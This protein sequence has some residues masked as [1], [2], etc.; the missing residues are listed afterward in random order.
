MIIQ[1]PVSFLGREDT[2]LKGRLM[3]E[4]SGILAWAIEG[5]RY[6]TDVIG[7]LRAAG[8]QV[9]AAVAPDPRVALGVNDR[10]QLAE[11]AGILNDRIVR[12]WQREGVTVTDPATTWIDETV[13]LAPDVT[14]LVGVVGSFVIWRFDALRA[15]EI[16]HTPRL[17][18][19]ALP[20]ASS[21]APTAIEGSQPPAAA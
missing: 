19:V 9:S 14:L 16:A 10:V 15:E 20:Q 7:L 1:F 21:Q 5:E 3:S 12:R 6:L 17:V 13:S 11:A 2:T 4:L 8:D 18:P